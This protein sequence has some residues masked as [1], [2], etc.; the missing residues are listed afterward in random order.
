MG[1]KANDNSTWRYSAEY[2]L[3]KWAQVLKEI[4]ISDK[5]RFVKQDGPGTVAEY[6]PEQFVDIKSYPNARIPG[7][8]GPAGD[9]IRDAD[10]SAP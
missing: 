10:V 1:I 6:S 9:H 5:D 3:K 4:G 7:G 2:Q 8:V